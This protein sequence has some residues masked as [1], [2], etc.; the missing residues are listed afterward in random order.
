MAAL[1]V[2]KSSVQLRTM[3]DEKALRP[4]VEAELQAIWP[5]MQIVA[6]AK[7]LRRLG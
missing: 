1:E 3:Y 4:E 5:A 7:K 2:A 6:K